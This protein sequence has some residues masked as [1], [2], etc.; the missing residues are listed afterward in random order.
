MSLIQVVRDVCAVVGVAAPT[1][2]LAAISTNRTMFEM[3][4]CANEMAQRIAYD[5]RDWTMLRTSATLVGDGAYVP[6]LPDPLA[7]WTGT[8][9][10]DLP[11]NYKRMLLTSNVWRST[12]T[13]QP[14]SFYPD[15]DEWLQRRAADEGDNLGEWTIYGGQIHIDPIMAVG[16]SARFSYL[17]KNCIN[18]ASGGVSDRFA[19]DNDTYRLDERLLKL[20]MIFN[21]KKDKGSPYAENMGEYSDAI[22]TA[23]GH[24]KPAPIIVGGRPMSRNWFAHANY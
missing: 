9:G 13:Q 16:V 7:V 3:L 10:F 23:M 12:D 22:A 8:S 5:T 19:S 20:G 24:D 15:T 17:D 21:W 6:P 18:L 14:M 11:A 2:V 4:A 1:S